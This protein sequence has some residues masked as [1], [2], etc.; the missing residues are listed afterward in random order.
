MIFK[1]AGWS[2]NT[3]ATQPAADAELVEHRDT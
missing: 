1:L 2:W 3:G